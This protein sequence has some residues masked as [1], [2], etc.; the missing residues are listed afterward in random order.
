MQRRGGS[1]YLYGMVEGAN[2]ADGS[3]GPEVDGGGSDGGEEGAREFAGIETMLFEEG[4]A[5]AAW[6]KLRKKMGQLCGGEHVGRCVGFVR[7]RL[8]GG[9]GLERYVETGEIKEAGKVVWVE[10]DAEV[11]QRA[12]LRWVFGVVGGEHSCGRSGSLREWN[13]LLK[14]GNP[15]SAMMEFE[16]ERKADDA[17]AGDADVRTRC[18]GMHKDKFSWIWKRI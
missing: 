5:V 6:H 1:V 16:G 10:G 14:N 15:G 13:A 18:R 11:G 4:E 3:V 17:A 12:K 7:E 9:V 8:Q 2:Q